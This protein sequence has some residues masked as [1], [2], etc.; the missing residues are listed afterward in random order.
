MLKDS[1]S[2]L[3]EYLQS[4]QEA[5]PIYEVI[6][7]TG[8]A[9]RPEFTVAC[10]VNALDAVITASGQSKRGAEQA[11]AEKMLAMLRPTDK[12]RPA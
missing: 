5:V 10:R 6:A 12:D 9:H 3:Q 1:K 7:E 4:K 8:A 11:A 2:R